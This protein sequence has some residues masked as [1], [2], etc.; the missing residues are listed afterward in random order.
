ME[1]NKQRIR[2]LVLQET[3]FTEGREMGNAGYRIL[4]SKMTQR[5]CRD[6]PILGI[7]RKT[8]KRKP[9]QQLYTKIVANSGIK[10]EWDNIEAR[11]LESV[12]REITEK[13]KELVPL[14]RKGK[15]PFWDTQCDDALEI[16][17]KADQKYNSRKSQE[18]MKEL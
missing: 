14:K 13:A 15:H 12:H 6:A 11:D 7:K 4:K 17:K 18:N 3:R 9:I 8:S 10:E 16:R 1:L 2:I 5:V